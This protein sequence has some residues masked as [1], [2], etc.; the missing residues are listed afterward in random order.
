V[1]FSLT[2][3]QERFRQEVRKFLEEEIREGYWEPTT[4]CWIQSFN[5]EFTKKVA[6]KGW[7][8]LTWPKE[9]GGRGRSYMDRLILAEEMLRYGAPVACHW[10]TDRQVGGGILSF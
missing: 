8:G 2:E 6:Q 10:F 7:I 9:Y 1:D 5:L 4:D 3:E